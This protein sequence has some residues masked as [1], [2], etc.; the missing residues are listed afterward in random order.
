VIEDGLPG[1]ASKLLYLRSLY[2]GTSTACCDIGMLTFVSIKIR[3]GPAPSQSG[4]GSLASLIAWGSVTG[5]T[6]SG[7]V[8]CHSNIS[9]V[10]GVIGLLES[11]TVDP[12]LRSPFYDLGTWT[13]HATGFTATPFVHEQVA[14]SFNRSWILRGRRDE[15]FLPALPGAWSALG[16]GALLAGGAAWAQWRRRSGGG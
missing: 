13:F 3:E 10:C 1:G 9:Y 14:P 2:D 11:G 6:L 15:F 5:W 8:F 12:M 7:S 4:S 16:A